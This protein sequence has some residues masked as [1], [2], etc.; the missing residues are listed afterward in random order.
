MP[1]IAESGSLPGDN[2]ALLL[3]QPLLIEVEECPLLALVVNMRDEHRPTEVPTINVP[4]LRRNPLAGRDKEVARVKECVPQKLPGTAVE[5]A[6]PALGLYDHHAG[7]HQRV[8]GVVVVLEDLDLLDLVRNWRDRRLGHI[9]GVF[10]PYAVDR[11]K[12]SARAAAVHVEIIRGS[13]SSRTHCIDRR[14][15]HNA[16]H[17]L[18]KALIVTTIER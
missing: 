14:C 11:V 1:R 15:I 10:I 3:P 18:A 8:L 2:A 13:K 17:Q 12:R 5:L 6:G 9:T 7:A 4:L 16:R